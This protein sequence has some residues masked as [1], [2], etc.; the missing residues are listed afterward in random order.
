MVQWVALEADTD[1]AVSKRDLQLITTALSETK[2]LKLENE[3]RFVD[4]SRNASELKATPDGGRSAC[5]KI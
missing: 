5:S 3:P 4:L 2:A 1:R